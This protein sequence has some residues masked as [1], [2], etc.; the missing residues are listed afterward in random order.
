[1]RLQVDVV[2]NTANRRG[3]DGRHNAIGDGL[4]RQVLARPMQNS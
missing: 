2:Q 1:V 3:T 4:P